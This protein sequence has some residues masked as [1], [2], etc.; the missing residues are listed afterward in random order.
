M[1]FPLTIDGTVRVKVPAGCKAPEEIALSGLAENLEKAKVSTIRRHASSLAFT[2]NFLRFV[3]SG[4]LLVPIEDGTIDVTRDADKLKVTYR[5]GTFRL[6]FIV[7][8]FMV[9]VFVITLSQQGLGQAVKF[10]GIGWG[11]L[12]G[13]NYLIALIRFRWFA[14]ARVRDALG[15]DA[16][17]GAVTRV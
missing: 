16:T 15:Q 10:T 14:W 5:L 8:A 6:F 12:F 9:P 13:G 7:T 17:S 2:V 1:V 3:W 4:N 11:W